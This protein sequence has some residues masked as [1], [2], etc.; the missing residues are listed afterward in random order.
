MGG[1][2]LVVM[3]CLIAGVPLALTLKRARRPAAACWS[4]PCFP[5]WSLAGRLAGVGPG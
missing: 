2:L 5:L 4:R 1:L 3:A